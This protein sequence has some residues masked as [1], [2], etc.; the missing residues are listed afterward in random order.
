M[1]LSFQ[2]GPMSNDSPLQGQS[3]G[4][5]ILHV[6]VRHALFMQLQQPGQVLNQFPWDLRIKGCIPFA[7]FHESPRGRP[8]RAW[9]PARI[10]EDP[11]GPLSRIP[12]GLVA[13][14]GCHPHKASS[15]FSPAWRKKI[16]GGLRTP[17][18][19]CVGSL[20]RVGCPRKRQG[21]GERRAAG[22]EELCPGTCR[23][24]QERD[25]RVDLLPCFHGCSPEEKS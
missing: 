1:F 22:Q 9:P 4:D 25:R 21:P 13:A 8:R 16:S 2:R 20:L 24:T 3:L 11:G 17:A 5:D 23:R 15:R 12:M 7:L 14:A 18:P 10:F 6:P 19:C